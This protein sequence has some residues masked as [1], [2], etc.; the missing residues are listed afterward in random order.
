MLAKQENG[1]NIVIRLQSEV[2]TFSRE[3]GAN[4]RT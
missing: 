3:D 2:Q 1:A 4:I